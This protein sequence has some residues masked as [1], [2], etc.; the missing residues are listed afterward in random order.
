MLGKPKGYNIDTVSID[1]FLVFHAIKEEKKM[2][3]KHG[4]N[5][6][7]RKKSFGFKHAPKQTTY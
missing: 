5:Y 6:R 4:G 7:K 1:F 3:Q 2:T